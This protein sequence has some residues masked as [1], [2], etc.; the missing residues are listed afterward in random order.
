M[1][2]SHKPPFQEGWGPP[3]IHV[4]PVWSVW[5]VS[6]SS[7][8]ASWNKMNQGQLSTLAQ[9]PAHLSLHSDWRIKICHPTKIT[10]STHPAAVHSGKVATLHPL[11]WKVRPH[12]PGGA[13]EGCRDGNSEADLASGHTSSDCGAS[14]LDSSAWVF[15]IKAVNVGMLGMF[16]N[17]HSRQ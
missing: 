7:S 5:V 9:Q 15:S 2:I 16:S 10:K 13:I 17:G 3:I 12:W 14:L 11:Y 4:Y 1:S 8:P 6:S